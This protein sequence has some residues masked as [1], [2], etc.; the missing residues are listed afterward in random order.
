LATWSPPAVLQPTVM[1]K[2]SFAVITMKRRRTE[3]RDGYPESL[4]RGERGGGGKENPFCTGMVGGGGGTTS[5]WFEFWVIQ[6][7]GKEKKRANLLCIELWKK[8]KPNLQHD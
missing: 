6:K 2:T 3:V 4:C 8:G 1:Q 5:C 7:R